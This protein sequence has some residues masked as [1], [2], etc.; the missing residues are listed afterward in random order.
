MDPR[1]PTQ[2]E[3]P[4]MPPGNNLHIRTSRDTL[5]FLDIEEQYLYDYSG[6]PDHAMKESAH[7]A[8]LISATMEQFEKRVDFE[9]WLIAPE[10][11]LLVV[12][13][14]NV[15]P[16]MNQALGVISTYVKDQAAYTGSVALYFYHPEE[17]HQEIIPSDS[18]FVLRCLLYQL[19]GF[20]KPD[21]ELK[22]NDASHHPDNIKDIIVYLMGLIP[23]GRKIFIFIHGLNGLFGRG[24]NQEEARA[25]NYEEAIIVDFLYYLMI[26]FRPDGKVIK[27]MLTPPLPL[28][29]THLFQG[30][31]ILQLITRFPGLHNY[32]VTGVTEIFREKCRGWMV[33]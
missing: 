9:S 16:E 22:W 12:K 32:E 20:L 17:Y 10:S 31:D 1:Q 3:A 21:T 6:V 25:K 2:A 18:S 30:E 15:K 7:S 23:N 33:E 14:Q 24:K 13:H 26:K 4:S 5:D 27:I 11:K 28:N 29:N 8:G 19:L